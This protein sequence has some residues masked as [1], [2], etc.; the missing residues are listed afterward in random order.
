MGCRRLFAAGL[1]AAAL[2]QAATTVPAYA[3]VAAGVS[4]RGDGDAPSRRFPTFRGR[5]DEEAPET[6]APPPGVRPLAVDI[7]TTKNF[8]KDQALWTDKRYF[9]CN[10]P[11]QLLEMYR[12]FGATPNYPKSAPW[13]DCSVDY[14]RANIVSPYP[15]KTAREH[16]EALAAAARAKGGPTVYTK[17]TTPD[18]DGYYTRAD[19]A[20]GSGQWIWGSANQY[21]TILSLLTPEYQTRMIQGNYHEA[22]DNA[23]QHT[24]SFCYPEGFVRWWAVASQGHNFQLTMTPWNVQFLSGIADNF[25]RQVMIGKQHVQKVPQWYG[26]TVGFWDGTTLVTWTA[27]VQPWIVHSM[28]EYS[29]KLETVETY[30]PA[31]D[32]SG[33]FIGLDHEVV[34]Y[35]PEAFA[36]PLRATYRFLRQ[37]TPDDPNRRYTYIE[38][39]T[40]VMNTDGRPGQVTKADPR[41]VDYYGRPWAQ[42][43]E[44]YFEKGW[45]KPESSLVPSDVLNLLQ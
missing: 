20:D 31:L 36:A 12:R 8:Y 33:K 7:F 6:L 28:F 16:Y 27:N 21:P 35:D 1:L 24:A 5:L 40:N 9:R 2:L 37:A 34:F 41:Y 44:K 42:V 4:V 43:W 38:C 26:E 15:Y 22:I 45:D 10:S 39:L 14:P 23:P 25:L 17:A 13:G 11:R 19:P 32:A 29:G 3:Q 30:K 18:W